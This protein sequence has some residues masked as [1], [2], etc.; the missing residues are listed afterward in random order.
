MTLCACGLKGPLKMPSDEASRGRATLIESLTPEVLRT[1]PAPASTAHPMPP[2]PQ[3]VS[4][5][6][7][8]PDA[9]SPTPVTR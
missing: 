2:L 6:P 8:V 3:P 1:R 7:A 5:Q 4:T 9:L